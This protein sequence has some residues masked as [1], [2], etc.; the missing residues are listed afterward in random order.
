MHEEETETALVP[1]RETLT[2]DVFESVPVEAIVQ[3]TKKVHEIAKAVM[4]DGIHYGKIPG[5]QRPTLLKPGAQI[6]CTTFMFC[7]SFEVTHRILEDDHI[8]YEVRCVLEHIPTGLKVATGHGSCSSWEKKYRY[9]FSN[10]ACPDC[11]QE[12]VLKSNK[13][14]GFFC[15]R[16]KGGCGAK[17]GPG[18]HRISSQ[19]TG[20]VINEDQHDQAN[21]ILKMA[22]KRAFVDATLTATCASDIYTQ[23]VEDMSPESLGSHGGR[24]EERTPEQPRERPPSGRSRQQNG[25]RQGAPS[26]GGF[27]MPRSR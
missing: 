19:E 24:R 1:R 2:L 17:F 5:T 9:R 6:L 8:H 12:A 26:G 13:E 15:W 20:K 7:P 11:G 23:D 18:D 3:R 21:T 14:P 27:P 4:K 16:K 10:R 25:S 22:Q